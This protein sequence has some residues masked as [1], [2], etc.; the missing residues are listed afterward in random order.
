VAAIFAPADYATWRDHWFLH[1]NVLLGQPSDNLN[2]AVSGPA[3]DPDGDGAHNFGEFVFGGD[4]Y[5]S[6][7]GVMAPIGGQHGDAPTLSYLQPA[8]ELVAVTYHLEGSDDL[9]TWLAVESI[10]L[11][12]TLAPSGYWRVTMRED[13]PSG[14]AK[15]FLR[16]VAAAQP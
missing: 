13:S 9:R 11:S 16:C 10:T 14:T 5:I 12:R 3:A 1:A 6:D 15:P 8:T 4:P 2:D 7:A